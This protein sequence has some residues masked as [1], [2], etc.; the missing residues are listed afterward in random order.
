MRKWACCSV[1]LVLLVALARPVVAQSVAEALVPRLADHN[2][3]RAVQRQI[4]AALGRATDPALRIAQQ[5]L[6]TD[7]ARARARRDAV[8]QS[9]EQLEAL[10]TE[11]Q[12]AAADLIPLMEAMLD[13]L[14]D[15]VRADLPIRRDERLAAIDSARKGLTDTALTSADR[16]AAVLSLYRDERRLGETINLNAGAVMVGTPPT[17]RRL[18]QFGRVALFAVSDDRSACALYQRDAATWVALPRDQCAQ[19]T[20]VTD[21]TA[22]S[23]LANLPTSVPLTPRVPTP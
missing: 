20:M 1:A 6:A 18:L 23:Q 12:Q 9:V 15:S 3:A 14:E 16:F 10:L 7:L 21:E 11:R 2:A 8:R 22:L 5:Q 4:D 17:Q 13:L 19:L